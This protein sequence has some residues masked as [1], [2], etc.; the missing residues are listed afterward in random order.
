[1]T[2]RSRRALINGWLGVSS[3][4]PAAKKAGAKKPVNRFLG[5]PLLPSPRSA[6]YDALCS[7]RSL[8]ATIAINSE[9]VGFAF[10]TLTV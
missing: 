3:R 6:L 9:L 8:S 5:P 10:E 7:S 4:R 1:M 2:N